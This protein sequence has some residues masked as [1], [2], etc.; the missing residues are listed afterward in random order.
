MKRY[1]ILAL[2]GIIAASLAAKAQIDPLSSQYFN[3]RYQ[4]NPAFAGIEH[5]TNLNLGYRSLYNNIPGAP[6]TQAITA[7]HG[8]NK[9]AGQLCLSLALKRNR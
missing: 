9:G 2:A 5:G 6:V 7:D 8:F 4:L 3:N 1:K